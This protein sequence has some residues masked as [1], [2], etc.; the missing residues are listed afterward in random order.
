M[1]YLTWKA[2]WALS[3][4]LGLS[5]L[6]GVFGQDAGASQAAAAKPAVA[7]SGK[8]GPGQGGSQQSTVQGTGT[9]LFSRSLDD[10]AGKAA[11]QNHPAAQTPPNVAAALKATD[12][13][14][15]S[16][17]FL[18][19]QLD[20]RLAPREQSMAVRARMKVRNDGAR[21]LKR[22][23]LQI[24]STLKWEQVRSD[25]TA[26]VFAQ[27][28]VESDADH[29]GT[30]N[31][32]VVTLPRELAPNE[33]LTL[34]ALYSGV[35]ALTSERLERI[36]A[37]TLTAEH[38]DWDRVSPEFIGLRG[39]GNVLWYPVNAQPALLG[40][41][42]K[43]FA[44][45]GRQMLRN[46]DARVSMTVTSEFSA[47]APVP[48]LAVL[49]GHVTPVV[50][51]AAPE[52]SYPGVV[53]A[54]LPETV[55]GFA[56]PS[57][58]LLGRAK[59]NGGVEVYAAAEDLSGAQSMVTAASA[60]TPLVQ[61]WLGAKPKSTLAVVG[62]PE[63]A[64]AQAEE[65]PVLFTGFKTSPDTAQLENAMAHSLAHAYFQSPRVWLNEGVPQFLGSL[66]IEQTA[67][68][69]S[70][71]E[72]LASAR[73]SLALAEPGSPGQGDGEDLIRAF[74]SIYYRTKATYVLWMLR[75]LAGDANLAAAL[76]AYDPGQDTTPDYFERLVERSSGKDL[77]W[78][79]DAWVYRD[80]G[81]PDLSIGGVFPSQSSAPGQYLVAV[82]V[83]NDGFAAAE[84]PLT[85]T[86][87][88]TTITQRLRVPARGKVSHRVLIAGIP[89]EIR[90]N[91]GTVP[92]TQDSLHVRNLTTAAP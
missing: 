87:N 22:I 54:T 67:G 6:Q 35:I 8:P 33:E 13:E 2:A 73:S 91:D 56:A 5:G 14:R 47:D 80:L 27:H 45:I 30:V 49:D 74:D 15:G 51:K 16:L 68:R 9:V 36:G 26:L 25:A 64:D 40:D 4:W 18:S 83:A 90:L 24:S 70:A 71:L 32:A 77:K 86:S 50:E 34:D 1:R 37:P 42:A 62:L 52:N 84:V 78:F 53:T 46:Q 85:V 29:S 75:D 11:D 55:L 28:P 43:L 23:A 79:F 57:L 44:E 3:I 58:F 38:S 10:D 76:Q 69:Q 63:A 81:L 72:A 17:T 61:Q 66:W 20:V 48:N 21:P 88:K 19:Y 59:V 65:G 12:E 82:D 89:T 39:F 31:E 92:E 41:G 60:V 7:E